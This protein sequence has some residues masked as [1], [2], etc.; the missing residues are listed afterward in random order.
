MNAD[1]YLN[2]CLII[3]AI[4]VFC[5]SCATIVGRSSE[6]KLISEHREIDKNSSEK[7]ELS[8]EL[9]KLANNAIQV[10]IKQRTLYPDILIQEYDVTDTS[11]DES[12]P[13]RWLFLTS[14][15]PIAWIMGDFFGY[16]ELFGKKNVWNHKKK[17]KVNDGKTTWLDTVPENYTVNIYSDI[18]CRNRCFINTSGGIGTFSSTQ[19]LINSNILSRE[20]L[21]GNSDSLKFVLA[22]SGNNVEK[23]ISVYSL[24]NNVDEA[25]Q[26]VVRKREADE[27]ARR[28]QAIK[29]AER[30]EAERRRLAY[31]QT[32]EYRAQQ[33]HEAE[34][35][36]CKTEAHR[37]CYQLR[38]RILS[39]CQEISRETER[40]LAIPGVEFESA[41][42]SRIHEGNRQHSK[43]INDLNTNYNSC[44]NESDYKCN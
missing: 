31:M 9:T 27:E 24:E 18:L 14:W 15:N 32:P 6:R 22:A 16:E 5:T 42:M 21:S 41:K 3:V 23:T 38:D 13:F 34:V 19:A 1:F 28:Q 4:C 10:S 39:R 8:M 25:N 12:H 40:L 30:Q 36:R 2:K 35:S 11:Y 17:E 33:Q 44:L 20:R 26:I 43:C 37:Q 7:V 29:E